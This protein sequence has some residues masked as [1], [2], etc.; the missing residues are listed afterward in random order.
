MSPKG[1]LFNSGSMISSGIFQSIVAFSS[2]LILVRFLS[3][4]EFGVFAII[5]ANATLL[6]AFSNLRVNDLII[7]SS[8]IELQNNI[9]NYFGYIISLTIFLFVGGLI[10]IY[11]SGYFGVRSFLVLLAVVIGPIIQFQMALYERKL[12]YS[13]ISK[14]ESG[15]SLLSHSLAALGVLMGMGAIVLYLRILALPI[16]VIIGLFLKKGF[17]RLPTIKFSSSHISNVFKQSKWIWLDSTLEQVFERAIYILANFL[18]NSAAVGFFFQAKRLSVVPHQLLQPFT[19]RVLLNYLSKAKPKEQHTLFK[20]VI[21]V[22]IIALSSACFI[23]YFYGQQLVHLLFGSKWAPVSEILIAL[24]GVVAFLSIYNSFKAFYIAKKDVKQFIFFGRLSFF[25]S[26]GISFLF[27][28]FCFNL[29][30]N[31]LILA[32]SIS[33]GYGIASLILLLKYFLS[34]NLKL[35]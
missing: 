33:I 10:F 19:T 25:V 28:K 22:E 34:T 24:L 11:L 26:L 6:A 29:E 13:N 21:L 35:A 2:N 17:M 8:E 7:R 4:S 12:E 3:P 9:E 23:L 31:I 20:K 16:F 27:F 18:G 1:L 14:I 5:L 32:Y 15:S 30:S